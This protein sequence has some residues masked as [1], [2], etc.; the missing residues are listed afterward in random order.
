[1]KKE[2]G[3]RHRQ[4][5]EYMKRELSRLFEAGRFE[6]KVGGLFSIVEVRPSRDFETA[7]VF[8]SHLDA[9]KTG[10][11]VDALNGIAGEIRY[12]LA[13][14]ASMRSTP[15]LIFRA[16]SAPEY[17]RRIGELLDSDDVRK[18]LA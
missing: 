10:E 14:S 9:A 18:D 8:V 5:G 15:A 12:K 17:A 3:K 1:M 13:H 11:L 16:D 7:M 6:Y 4:V 2:I